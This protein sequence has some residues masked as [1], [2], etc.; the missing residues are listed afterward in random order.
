MKYL[1]NYFQTR[2]TDESIVT[3]MLKGSLAGMLLGFILA[4]LSA[5]W[6]WIEM[7]INVGLMIP[8]MT[9]ICMAVAAWKG[10]IFSAGTFLIFQ[11]ILLII[12]LL[13]YGF[14]Y[15]A[16]SVVPASLFRE[17][18][19]AADMSLH[20]TNIILV[21]ILGGGNLIM[22]GRALIRRYMAS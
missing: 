10:S 19:R 4:L 6:V 18:F 22:F 17:G 13:L 5:S 11:L 9:L 15:V 1:H 7:R 3:N 20:V 21:A 16:L 2:H 12:F 8:S 14:D